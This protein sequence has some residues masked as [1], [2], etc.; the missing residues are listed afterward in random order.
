MSKNIV[1]LCDGTAQ[2]GG[3]G[4]DTNIYKLFKMLE[5]RTPSQ[6]V[7]YDPGLGTDWR[8]LTGNAAGMG[9]SRNIDQCYRFI[10]EHFEA[11]DRIYLLGFS[12]GAATVVSL[13]HFIHHFGM[14]PKSRPELIGKA[15]RY[16][17]RRDWQGAADFVARHHTMWTTVRFLGVWDTVAALGVPIPWLDVLVDRVPFFRHRFHRF[18]LAEVVEHGRH[19]LAIDDDR[20]SFH[21]E[22]W[23]HVTGRDGTGSRT[24]KQVWFAGSHSDVGGG[25]AEPQLS[26]V[27]LEWMLCEATSLAAGLR[28]R[29]HHG[30]RLEPSACGRLHDPRASG[31][32]RLYRQRPRSWPEGWGRP[33]VHESVVE[34]AAWSRGLDHGPLYLPWLLRD[35][36]D[37][38]RVEPWVRWQDASPSLTK[39]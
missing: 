25:Y 37:L 27:A 17:R 5:N 20:L 8:K 29:P 6:V 19:A 4:R 24:M 38:Y 12:R 2:E 23:P 1:V 13:S 34:R 36:A 7:F 21:P 22:L 39:T 30:V 26:D 28:I 31:F 3:V 16:Y 35:Y 33:V 14:L 9:I 11:G 15:W 18:D 10:S 32:G